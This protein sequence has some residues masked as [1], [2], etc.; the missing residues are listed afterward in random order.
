MDSAV[1]SIDEAAALAQDADIVIAVVGDCLCQNGEA[2][3]RAN[4]ELSG[5]QNELVARL[6]ETGKPV[7]TVLVNGKPLCIGEVV[8]HSDAVIESF[9]M[10]RREASTISVTDFL[11]QLMNTRI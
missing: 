3:D 11:S 2:K 9:N 6:K 5:R 10:W 8:R 1:E 7:I 4:L